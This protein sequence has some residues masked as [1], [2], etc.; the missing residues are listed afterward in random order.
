MGI[1]LSQ[2]QFNG[3]ERGA[4]EP[5]S[6]MAVN[7]AR[8]VG[9]LGGVRS[10]G[11]RSYVDLLAGFEVGVLEHFGLEFFHGGNR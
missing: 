11:R 10:S 6:L 7:I 4:T 8:V 5:C 1:M 9:F 3:S 2:N